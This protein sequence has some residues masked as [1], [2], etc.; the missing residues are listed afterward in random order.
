MPS[1][2]A[3]CEHDLSADPVCAN[4]GFDNQVVKPELSPLG[5]AVALNQLRSNMVAT[6]A[7]S[8]PNMCYPIV[9]ML[10]D[11]GF[12]LTEPSKEQKQEHLDCYGGAGGYPGKLKRPPVNPAPHPIGE[13]E[14]QLETMLWKLV[15]AGRAV[16][17]ELGYL[18]KNHKEHD[19][20]ETEDWRN[21]MNEA[22]EYV[23]RTR[24]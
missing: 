3:I 9:A 14:R 11:T 24:Y 2:C 16:D 7:A 15:N 6:Q 22:V 19:Y 23:K 5:L 10:E 4:C 13:R 20:P 1:D 12:R 17:R 18:L 21:A 8:W